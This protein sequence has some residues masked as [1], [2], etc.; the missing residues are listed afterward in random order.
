MADD[1]ASGDNR[2]SEGW[3]HKEGTKYKYI[4]LRDL[5]HLHVPFLQVSLPQSTRI[6]R[7]LIM[8]IIS[9]LSTFADCTSTV[10][11]QAVCAVH[12]FAC[13]VPQGSNMHP[14]I[15]A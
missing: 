1:G 9:T 3:V 11:I 5:R 2:N 8:A 15:S 14:L 4:F 7:M 13:T 12:C 10:L 6:C